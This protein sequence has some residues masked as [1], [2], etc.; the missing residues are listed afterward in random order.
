VL[1]PILQM[2]LSVLGDLHDRKAVLHPLSVN[3]YVPSFAI[4]N[5]ILLAFEMGAVDWLDAFV[6][7]CDVEILYCV[8][9]EGN[10]DL[11]D[12]WIFAMEFERVDNLELS[13][14]HHPLS[15]SRRAA[16]FFFGHS[17]ENHLL[18]SFY[19]VHCKV[20]L[21]RDSNAP[22]LLVLRYRAD[23]TLLGMKNI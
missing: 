23:R 14:A 4:Y 17:G 1:G 22:R 19:G 15:E 16:V 18:L 12:G 21:E 7:D 10:L 20:D 5:S 8:V 13:F 9:L 6:A 11:L 3:A 2:G